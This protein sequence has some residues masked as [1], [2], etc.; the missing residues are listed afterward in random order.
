[1][2][3]KKTVLVDEVAL[4]IGDVGHLLVCSVRYAL[5]R[6]SYI[7]STIAEMVERRWSIL[8]ENDRQVILRDI[9]EALADTEKAG[10]KL[11]MDMDDRMWR[12]LLLKLEAAKP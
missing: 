8:S 3:K 5:G 9:K 7:T 11:G 10:R 6:L 1:M 12:S 2:T 4:P